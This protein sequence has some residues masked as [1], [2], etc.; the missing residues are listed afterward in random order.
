MLVI[1]CR[2]RHTVS[3]WRLCLGCACG[4]M[5]PCRQSSLKE[6]GAPMP[7]WHAALER[8]ATFRASRTRRCREL[9]A[10]G[11]HRVLPTA[12]SARQAGLQNCCPEAITKPAAGAEKE[13]ASGRNSVDCIRCKRP[14]RQAAASGLACCGPGGRCTDHCCCCC[15][16]QSGGLPPGAQLRATASLRL[17]RL[18]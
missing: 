7:M 9:S 4:G 13:E 16:E 15:F 5:R 3:G 2:G 1:S 10:P 18:P 8:H 14:G 17:P 12:A 6:F 11:L